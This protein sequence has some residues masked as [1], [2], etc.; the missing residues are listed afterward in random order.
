ME[1]VM[2][3]PIT[4]ASPDLAPITADYDIVGELGTK[5]SVRVLL[6]TKKSATG[7]RR[8][9]DD[10]VLIEI[11]PPPAGDESHALQHLASDITT[12]SGL[13]HRRLVK[14]LE[15]RWLGADAFAVI[16]E[17]V[18]DPSIAERIAQGETFTNT[19]TAAILREVHGLLEWAREQRIVHRN[20][21]PDRIFLEPVSDRVR[22]SFAA[23]PIPRIRTIDPETEDA[24]SV[25]R[26]AVTMMS[27]HLELAETGEYSLAA[28][29]PDLPERLHEETEALLS[30][31]KP[32]IDV[33]SYLA[34]IGMADPVAEGESERDRI[35]AEVLE[36][37]RVEREKLANERAEFER[38]REEERQAL[39]A[40]GEE[41]RRVFAAETAKL[42]REFAEAQAALAAERVRMQRILADERTALLVKQEELERELAARV[43]VLD[44]AAAADRATIDELRARIRVAGELEVERKRT[45]ALEEIDD[46]EIRLETGELK[47]P[48]FVRPYIA[49]LDKITFR[50]N[51]P[52]APETIRRAPKPPEPVQLE[53]VVEEL[54]LPRRKPIQ[55][56]RWLVPSAVAA[57]I[58]I[59]ASTIAIGHRT[60]NAA[61]LRRATTST[62]SGAMAPPAASATPAARPTVATARGAVVT[63]GSTPATPT[64][65]EAARLWLDSIASA[66]PMDM[67]AALLQSEAAEL[68]FV[69]AREA[70]R[71]RRAFVRD[72]I[73]NAEA[74]I[75]PEEESAQ[76]P[77]L[78][79][80]PD[81]ST[82]P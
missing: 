37:Q 22:I 7:S 35:R 81:S 11:V 48:A 44:R 34:L 20:V 70:A 15:G 3:D 14:T 58:A 82:G 21:T 6:A 2:P 25:V 67:E 9:D 40:E 75:V 64:G 28:L 10:R 39:A 69:R 49:S 50:N 60:T 19:R 17:R 42:E 55:W 59:A 71:A 13:R 61:A 79:A 46:A 36:E 56:R 74:G 4:P 72:S 38:A 62:T 43:A 29:R 80:P 16:R 77:G 33:P 47:T 8:D 26:L 65:P 78:V 5:S 1:P 68:R 73:E 23:G 63:P 45:M 41:L 66:N 54:K 18:D 52:L 57:A 76:P 12:L 32:G 24:L 31:P 27:G 51:D 53:H 30:D